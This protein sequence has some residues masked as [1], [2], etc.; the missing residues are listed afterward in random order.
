MPARYGGIRFYDPDV[1]PRTTPP[2]PPTPL[3]GRR[4]ELSDLSEALIG[5]GTRLITVTGPPGVGKTR[6]ALAAAGRVAE[7]FSAGTV[8]VDLVPLGEPRLVLAEIGRALGV[9]RSVGEPALGQLTL[10]VAD[11]DVLLVLDNFEHVLAAAPDVGALLAASPRM[12]ILATSR[13]RL[14]LAAEREFAVPPLAM[15]SDADVGHVERLRDNPAVALL[16][17]RAPSHVRLTARTAHALAEI[18]VRLDGLP[19]ALELAAARLRVFTPSELS[20]RLEHQ[21]ARLAG[22]LRDVP[23]RH[24]DLRAAIAWSYDLLPES[25]RALFRR[26][27]IFVGEWTVAAAGAVY[28]ATATGVLDALESLL[29]KSLVRRVAGEEGDARFTM[30]MSLR[31]FAAEQLEACDELPETRRKHVAY[32]ADAA[33]RWEATVGTDEETATW[34]RIGYLRGDLLDAF[35]SRADRADPDEMLWLATALGWFWYTRGSLADATTFVETVSALVEDARSSLDARAAALIAAGIVAFGLGDL[36]NAQHQLLRSAQL[37]AARHDERR[38][39]IASAFLGHVARRRAR[40]KEA[41]ERYATAL[42]IYERS[43]NKRGTAW[44]AHDLGL[45]AAEFGDLSEAQSQ[46]RSALR[47]FRSVDYEWA[48]AVSSCALANV[49]LRADAVDEAAALLG[50]ALALHDA[51]GDRRGVAQCLEGLAEVALARGA[52]ATAGRL[53]GAAAAQRDAVAVRPTEAEHAQLGRVGDAVVTALGRHGADHEQHSGRTMPAGAATALAAGVAAAAAPRTPRPFDVELTAR[54]R[55]VAAL[56]AAGNTNRQIGRTLGI[57]EKTAEI[58]VRNIMARLH[59]T[60][61]AGIA[62]WASAHGLQA[63]P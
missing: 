62:A 24:R 25:E 21:T 6:L 2:S 15:P 43:G 61:R 39:A 10:A 46:L 1:A 52:T 44:A 49:L 33:R 31:E 23:G 48:V 59:A 4:N 47:L 60:S 27:S 16:L 37:S 11:K 34:P 40:A 20:F 50:E 13:E 45:L 5:D 7:K 51:V 8:W 58:H 41:A 14:R 9:A 26:L 57:S 3:I 29:D 30:L 42:S 63:P 22:G 19:L 32:M 56:I 54:Q 35:A 53:L 55:E 18:C 28:S 36:D 38:L 12:R 17:A